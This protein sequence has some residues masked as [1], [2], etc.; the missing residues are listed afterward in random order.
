[1][2]KRDLRVLTPRGHGDCIL[3]YFLP[4]FTVMT[5]IHLIVFVHCHSVF[6]PLSITPR[7]LWYLLSLCPFCQT[8]PSGCSI[9]ALQGSR[10]LGLKLQKVPASVWAVKSLCVFSF[11]RLWF[12]P[13]FCGP[14]VI[15][16][17]P[18]T[19]ICVYLELHLQLAV[20]CLHYDT[21]VRK[22]LWGRC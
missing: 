11:C 16:A 1:M 20:S 15:A 12:S 5:F 6:G 14:F 21:L 19:D 17:V 13:F 18:G 8:P 4:F 7:S 22:L 9:S 10:G 3:M 2:I